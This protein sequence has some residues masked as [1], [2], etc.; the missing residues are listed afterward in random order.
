MG[1]LGDVA[2]SF[3]TVELN[4]L[5]KHEFKNGNGNGNEK[6][7]T[8]CIFEPAPASGIEINGNTFIG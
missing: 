5:D 6:K 2:R 1:F 7:F 3:S 8:N 4:K